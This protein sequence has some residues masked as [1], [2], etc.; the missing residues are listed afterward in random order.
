[1]IMKKTTLTT[2]LLLIS[3]ILFAQE[4]SYKR[5][6]TSGPLGSGIL[7]IKG[8]VTVNDSIITIVTNK[9]PAQLKVFKK[10]ENENLKTYEMEQPEGS[11]FET[12]FSLIL[13]P[14]SKKEDAS[15]ILE[16]KDNFRNELTTTTYPLILN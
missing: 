13:T 15:L 4:Y 2:L 9:I 12:R 16:M 11:D 8:T 7:K 14:F 10:F 6:I 5:I 3:T 1:M